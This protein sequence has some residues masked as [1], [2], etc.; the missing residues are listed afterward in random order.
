MSLRGR[1][2]S[3][4]EAIPSKII[5]IAS[6]PKNKSGG[7]QRH[8]GSYLFTDTKAK[9]GTSKNLFPFFIAI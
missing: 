4:P 3:S 8:A 6:P 9:T 1:F 2:C 5:E 7:S